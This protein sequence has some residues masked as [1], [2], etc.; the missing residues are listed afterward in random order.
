MR[1]SR[2]TKNR[3]SQSTPSRIYALV[4][5]AFTTRATSATLTCSHIP[6]LGDALLQADHA[7]GFEH[8]PNDENQK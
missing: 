3:A 4:A 2:L 8:E 1:I 6:K 5:P 7:H